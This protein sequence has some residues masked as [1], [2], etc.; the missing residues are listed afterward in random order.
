M[1]IH[2]KYIVFSIV[3]IVSCSTYSQDFDS[4]LNSMTNEPIQYTTATFKSTRIVN[5]HSIEQMKANELDFRIFHRF[6]PVNSGAYEFFGIDKYSNVGLSFE[7]G[8]KDWLMVG[9]GRDNS[10]NADFFLKTRLLRQCKGEK[11]IPVS[12]T[13]LSSAELDYKKWENPDR[14]NLFSSRLSYVN[15][16]LIARKF[17]ESLSL[18]I[19]PTVVHRNLVKTVI[20]PN[21]LYS[22]GIGGRY[23]IT[24]RMAIVSEY[25]YVYYP[26]KSVGDAKANSLSVGLDLETGGHV[27]TIVLS[28]SF[29][30]MDKGFITET[31]DSWQHGDIH[32]GFNISRVFSL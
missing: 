20:E 13:W 11:N 23:K 25:Y 31:T 1:N 7:Y 9:V 14:T 21:D 2:K 8:I 4:L 16:I 26:I 29:R 3:M 32:L 22:I 12:V 17:N 18:Q 15:Q 19:T 5:G 28:N 30:N 10:K 24:N 27:F 6:G